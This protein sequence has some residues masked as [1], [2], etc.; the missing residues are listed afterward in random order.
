MTREEARR[1]QFDLFVE[2]AVPLFQALGL[3][4]E[5]GV[6]GIED[7]DLANGVS[8]L[9]RIDHVL[10]FGDLAEH[11]VLSIQPRSRD[12]GDEELAAVG[13]WTGVGHREDPWGLMLE[14]TVDFVLELVAR[15]SAARAGGISA[16]NHKVRDD[17]VKRNPVVETT[18]GQ[19]EEIG[20]GQGD[21]AG[22]ES[23]FDVAFGGFED[24]ADVRHVGGGFL[25]W[26]LPWI[27]FRFLCPKSRAG[28]QENGNQEEGVEREFHGVDE[29]DRME[30]WTTSNK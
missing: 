3:G 27:F 13:V 25:F 21:F 10:T 1:E 26:W 11:S 8:G 28:S 7:F 19:V 22:E 9:D 14:G 23:S 6:G 5:E 15:T 17:A 16:L 2:D 30:G 18:G 29:F 20:A 12:V 4:S 24:D